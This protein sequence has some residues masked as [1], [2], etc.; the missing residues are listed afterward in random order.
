VRRQF[1]ANRLQRALYVP[2]TILAWLAVV[3]IVAWILGHLLRTLVMIFLAALVAFALAPLVGLFRRWVGRP[4]AIV[5]AY[6]LALLVVAGLG[7]L[8]VFTAADQ[9][10]NLVQHLPVYAQQVQRLE[11]QLIDTLGRVG[12]HTVNLQSL[13]QQAL[14]G[15]Q[16]VGGTLAAGSLG[17][18]STI[19]GDI[20]DGILI[21]ILSIYF[22]AEGS[23]IRGFVQHGVPPKMQLPARFITEVASQVVGG[24][25][26][27]T[28]TLAVLIGGLVGVGLSVIGL[29]YAVL[30]G[31]LAFLMEFIPIVGV[32]ISGAISLLVAL[33]QGTGTV[34]LVLAYF[35]VIHIIEGDVVGPRIMG[36]AVGIHPATGIIALLAGT[37]LFGV[38]GA[39]FASPV[40][41]LLQALTVA[42]WRGVIEA[43]GAEVMAE[44]VA[45]AEEDDAGRV[46]ER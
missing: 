28:L 15:A 14:A 46:I 8:L 39:L 41:G 24:Y 20:V 9:I 33:P 36:R 3:I 13:N 29:P 37:E 10:T 44:T 34:L 32:L 11:G 4:L 19:A 22:M 7:S 21:L 2:L 18:L 25:I 35:V 30:L 1:A 31:V 40:A 12:I 23:R 38:W 5:V 17:I 16:A 43:R 26:R 6:F 27:G 45:E 42:V